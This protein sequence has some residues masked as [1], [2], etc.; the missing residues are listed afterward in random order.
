MSRFWS[1]LTHELHP[2]VP[3]E[4]PRIPDLV[5]LNTNES[6]FGPSP[7]AMEA[8][9]RA[10]SFS[11]EVMGVSKDYGTVEAGKYADI[12]A[13]PGDP[14]RNIDNLRSPTIVIKFEPND[15]TGAKKPADLGARAADLAS[16]P[17]A[18]APG[19]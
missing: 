19:I 5:K 3:G 9:R 8:I 16:T 17:A 12:I 11:A 6:P 4:Q 1:R 2:Y 15:M 18:N 13:V 14:L 10:T 7:G